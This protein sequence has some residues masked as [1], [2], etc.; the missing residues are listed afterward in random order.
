MNSV[1]KIKDSEYFYD[2][3][4][5][6]LSDAFLEEF[7]G[8]QPKW[9]PL[10]YISYKR[11][12]SRTL[13]G[14]TKEEFWQ[15]LERVV[16]GSFTIQKQHCNGLGLPWNNAK[17]Q[18]TAQKMFRAMWEF[19]FL[20]PGRGLWIMGTEYIAKHGSAALNNCAFTST[21]DIDI[22]GTKA[23]EFMMDMSMLGVGVGFDTK[24]EGKIKITSPKYDNGV[25]EIPDSREGWVDSLKIQLDAFLFGKPKFK[26]DYSKIRPMGAI[27]KGFGGVSSGPE[28][29]AKLLNEVEELFGGRE[30]QF[31]SST[32][33]VDVM[34]FIGKCVVAGNVRRTAE[35]ALGR[36]DDIGFLTMKQDLDKLSSHRWASNNS[37]FAKIGDNYDSIVDSF[38]VNGEP[39]ICWLDNARKYGRLKDGITWAD[40]L[41]AGVNPCG[42]Q[43]LES[44]ELCCLV[45]TFPS[46]HDTFEEYKETLE[47]AY[48]YAKSVTLVNTHWAETNAVMMKNRRMGISQTGIINAFNK[49]GQQ[50][51]VE[52]CDKGYAHIKEFDEKYSDWLCIPRSKKLTTVKPSGTI[53]LLAGVCPGIHYPHSE[54]YIRRIR[55][56]RN[57]E[58][59]KILSDAGYFVEDDTYSKTS[60]V[61]EF[62]I[63]EEYFSVSKN[64]V[65]IWEQLEN[66]SLYQTYWSDNQ[67][68]I[69]INF[70]KEEVPAIKRALKYYDSKLKAVSFL[71]TE[72]HGYKQAPYEEITKE[73]YEEMSAKLK[74]YSLESSISA[75]AGELFCTT[76]ACEIKDFRKKADK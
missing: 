22:K 62:P 54:Y 35:I 27:I 51:M 60:V 76:D 69:T 5:F 30:G 38:S 31:L 33:I 68:S 63:K 74:P 56:D 7:K 23:F 44:Y 52:W 75:G 55:F 71:P 50:T 39:G 16:N 26:F 18:K 64:D 25:F 17:A 13:E 24:G 9:G 53:S 47:L 10:G 14:G 72:D 11:T 40:K 21:D 36:I 70:K 32:D 67:V 3:S 19:K 48:L 45:E 61:V 57:S 8:K 29:L 12:Y 73:K 41:A 2:I 1:R 43:T 46:N 58:Y 28:P 15:T 6:K 65:S 4:Y 37:V 42:E 66:A 20:P 49:F 59:V 34:N